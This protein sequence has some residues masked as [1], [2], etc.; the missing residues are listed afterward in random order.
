MVSNR[1]RWA[2]RIGLAVIVIAA[3]DALAVEPYAVAIAKHEIA[4]SVAAPLTVMH[5]TDLHTS[6][7]GRR[8][9]RVVEAIDELRP[10]VIVVTGDVV[11]GGSLEPARELFTRM[12]APLGVLVVRGN[13][14]NWSPPGDEASFYASVGATFL[15]NEGRL[16]RPDVW[17]GGVDD[18]MS[19]DADVDRAMKGAPDGALRVLLLHSPGSFATFADRVDLA[20]GGHTHGGQVRL[21][22][23]GPIWTPPGSDR[24]V[25]GWYTSGRARMF[26]SRGVGTSIFPVR[27]FCRPEIGAIT[28][29]SRP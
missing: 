7:F 8:E 14:E 18:P 10:D 28:I 5:L 13:W 22:F 23:V 17:I 11:D 9:R 29:R 6:G 21:P 20:F 16:V 3:I 24:F 12:R 2:S 15:V 1:R 19:G 4:A 27:F 25:E 26:V